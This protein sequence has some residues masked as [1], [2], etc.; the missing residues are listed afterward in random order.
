MLCFS[1]SWRQQVISAKIKNTGFTGM[2]AILAC[3]ECMVISAVAYMI[4]NLHQQFRCELRM[5][6][7]G[8]RR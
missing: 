7:L 3:M 2:P 6:E 5:I 8:Y 4:I 1:V